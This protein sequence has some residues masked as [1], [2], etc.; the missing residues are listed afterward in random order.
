MGEQIDGSSSPLSDDDHEENDDMPEFVKDNITVLEILV[1]DRTRS[2]TL[3][4]LLTLHFCLSNINLECKC[5]MSNIMHPL[6][7]KVVNKYFT[8]IKDLVELMFNNDSEN[9]IEDLD[10]DCKRDYKLQLLHLSKFSLTCIYLSVIELP[11]AGT[12]SDQTMQDELSNILT[13]SCGYLNILICR[14][15][16]H[17]RNKWLQCDRTKLAGPRVSL[18]IRLQFFKDYE[19]MASAGSYPH[20]FWKETFLN[21]KI[22]CCESLEEIFS[23][24]K[25]NKCCICWKEGED[26]KDN[27]AI[28]LRCNH[29][30]CVSCAELLLVGNNSR[31]EYVLNLYNQVI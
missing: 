26:F 4:L 17:Y 29:L 16:W 30:V 8:V 21:E 28:F 14:H 22:R 23:N 6:K 25:E 20:I 11:R 7:I 13:Q 18:P 5:F 24:G 12:E 15:G 9:L 3:S 1:K 10:S 19:N 2:S 31:Y 27:F